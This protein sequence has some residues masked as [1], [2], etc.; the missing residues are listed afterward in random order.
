[1][2]AKIKLIYVSVTT[3]L[4]T[5]QRVAKVCNTLVNQGY[6]VVLIGRSLPSSW[7]LDVSYR[8]KRFKLLFNKGPLF[9][10]NYSLRLFF[11]LLFSK[12]GV[13]L[14]NDLDTLLPN[15]LISIIK[16]VKLMYDSHEY[17]TEVP[18]LVK[19][20][21]VRFVWKKIEEFIVPK[22]HFAYTVSQPIADA[23]LREY[24]ISFKVIRN[25]PIPYSAN[26]NLKEENVIIYQ[27]ALNVGR[28]IESLILAMNLVDA[29]LWIAGDGDIAEE[30]KQLVRSNNLDTKV[31]FLGRLNVEELKLKTQKARIGISIEEEM[32]LNYTYAL[33]NKLFDYI[34]AGVPVLVSALPEMKKIVQCYN[35][36]EVLGKRDL[37][38]MAN[39][40]NKMLAS[41]DYST[42]R[43]NCLIAAKEL[44]W[45]VESK[46]L[47]QL[48]MLMEGQS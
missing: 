24:G 23:Y 2:N 5:D 45:A 47:N 7:S 43:N 28:G 10:A 4:C 22:L 17:F 33:P 35:V 12:K 20:P 42:W 44:N 32:G 26:L 21:F 41:A 39:Q 16:R 25:L 48:L 37:S 40:I 15:Y 3:D 30:L 46:K 19:R 27:G 29:I 11:Y 38:E 18:E 9:Y 31:L 36:G 13:L 8:I 1:M 14:S 6:E 34:Q